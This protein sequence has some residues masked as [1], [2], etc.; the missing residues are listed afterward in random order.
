MKSND[1]TEVVNHFEKSAK[2]Y[3]YA[4]N[5][6]TVESYGFNIR[7][8]IVTNFLAPY[9]GRTLDIGCGPGIMVDV[10]R[11]RVEKYVGI[12]PAESMIGECLRKCPRD[13][14]LSFE[15]GRV[16][17]INA[18]CN[19]FDTSLCL[20]VLEYVPNDRLALK[21][22]IRV[23]KTNGTIIITL[24]NRKSPCRIWRRLLYVPVR[25]YVRYYLLKKTIPMDELIVHREYIFRNY[26]LILEKYNCIVDKV[27]YYNFQIVPSPFD[28]W[29]KKIDLKLLH[30]LEKLSSTRFDWFGTGM[31]L[32]IIK[33]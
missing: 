20:G 3:S 10:L 30:N 1:P 26:E 9:C 27:S 19:Y 29:F 8:K 5:N 22:L 17:N 33:L 6:E 11:S 23:T 15:I 21:E 18:E 2:T 12:D 32:K 24:P 4:Y 16:E 28:K 7:K 14:R 25:R 13:Q 31:V